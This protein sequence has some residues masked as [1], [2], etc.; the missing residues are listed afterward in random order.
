M[1]LPSTVGPVGEATAY[2]NR[3]GATEVESHFVQLLEVPEQ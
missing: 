3:V 1:H 2:V